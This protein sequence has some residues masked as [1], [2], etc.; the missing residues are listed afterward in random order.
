MCVS[1]WY[2]SCALVACYEGEEDEAAAA[3]AAAATAAGA[4]GDDVK[5]PEGFTPEQQKKFNDAIAAERRKQETK[6][7][8][9]LEKTEATY[10]E[11]LANNKS[12]TEKER[13]T[14]QENL[15]MIQGQLR[16]KEE[17]AVRE[18]KELEA[19]YQGKLT[20]AE[21]RAQEAETR[22]RDSTVLRALQD[23]A[24]EHEAYNTRQVV[25]L[26]K[27][28]TKLVERVDASGKATGQFDVMVEF[29]DNDATTGQ[30]IKTTKTP[31]E[32]VKR[33]TEIA[34]FQNLFRK[35][36]VSGVGGNSAIGGLTTGSNGRIDP[37]SLTPDQYQK[38]RAE[39]PELLGL[40]RRRR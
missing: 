38:V 28:W 15:E 5:P 34:E 24:V 35:N 19:S 27:D 9:E 13:Q 39:N 36:V 33:M 25:M 26:L 4:T 32:A 11:L 3:A 18:K 12:L 17:Q 16:S 30:E 1:D 14:L 10:K 22:W 20:A 21:K 6:Y 29:P 8:K 23:A 40:R 37:R 7:R 31:S 2:K